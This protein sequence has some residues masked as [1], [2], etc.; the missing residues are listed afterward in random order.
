MRR[1]RRIECNAK[2]RVGRFCVYDRGE[3]AAIEIE[4]P[5]AIVEVSF[6]MS[7]SK[8]NCGWGGGRRSIAGELTDILAVTQTDKTDNT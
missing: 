3:G 7:V 4:S 2:P 6:F 5:D 1:A 8:H